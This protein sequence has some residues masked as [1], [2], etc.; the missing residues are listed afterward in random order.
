MV[1]KQK[2]N[3]EVES[4]KTKGKRKYQERLAQEREAKDEIK[5][6]D[7]GEPVISQEHPQSMGNFDAL[8]GL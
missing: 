6:Y 3:R 1:V 4:E 8:S 5:K 2:S 7:R